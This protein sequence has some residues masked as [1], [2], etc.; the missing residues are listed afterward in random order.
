MKFT[1]EFKPGDK[2]FLSNEIIKSHNLKKYYSSGVYEVKSVGA[3]NISVA[4][5]TKD[6]YTWFH[7]NHKHVKL[8]N[9]NYEIY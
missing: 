8:L 3:H 5:W 4:I 7:F 9:N 6:N 1:K 2:V